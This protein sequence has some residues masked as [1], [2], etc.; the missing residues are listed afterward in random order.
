M[1]SD[2]GSRRA[3]PARRQVRPASCAWSCPQAASISR[4][5]VSRTVAGT[6]R[7][8][9]R[10]RRRRPAGGV[11]LQR[12]PGVGFSGMRLTWLR[13]PRPGPRGGRP[14]HRLS[15]TPSIIT[16]SR[17][18]R[19]PVRAANRRPAADQH[20]ADGHLRLS[21][22]SSSRSASS[23]RVQ[24]DRQVHLRQLL[25]HAVDPGHHARGADR[26]VAGADPQ[27]R[28]VVQEAHRLEDAVGVVQRLAHAH[29]DDV[30]VAAAGPGA[31]RRPARATGRDASAA[32][33]RRSRRGSAAA[34]IPPGRSRRTG[35]PPRSP[36][37][38]L[39]QIV[40]RSSDRPR[41]G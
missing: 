6:R 35:S 20:L 29:E 27:P 16:Y 12:E 5:R 26:D 1:R 38:E 11:P 31:S 41:A 40:V 23:R 21:G 39:M 13:Q 24:A 37:G 18:T 25:D 32:P 8:G 17:L 10:R 15:F 34:R 14:A 9:A 7:R 4:P 36:P 33:G 30:V 22:T 3:A 28:G 2:G 19:R